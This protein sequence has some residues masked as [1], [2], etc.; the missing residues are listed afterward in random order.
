MA[1]LAAQAP[2]V[3]I[4]SST[5]RLAS[6]QT[7]YRV[8][9]RLVK[10]K[11]EFEPSSGKGDEDIHLVIADLSSGQTMIAE[12]PKLP[13]APASGSS[14]RLQM[15]KARN[16]FIAACGMPP[17]GSP[18]TLNGTAP[19]T[20]VGFF[21][22]HHSTPQLGRAPDDRELHPVLSFKIM[23]PWSLEALLAG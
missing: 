21:D 8:T 11:V 4:K 7:V 10:A 14:K 9:A 22:L 6:E 15:T 1:Q 23:T 13:C 17:S 18:A 5:P 12:F 3:A 2:P 20:A 19:L 16:A